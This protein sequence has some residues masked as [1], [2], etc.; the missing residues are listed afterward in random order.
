[1][2]CASFLEG[3]VAACF[4]LEWGIDPA[5]PHGLPHSFSCGLPFLGPQSG[6]RQ[7]V[8]LLL[9]MSAT[10]ISLRSLDDLLLRLLSVDLVPRL[11]LNSPFHHSEVIPSSAQFT[12]RL[13]RRS[14]ARDDALVSSALSSLHAF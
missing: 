11:F 10:L 6:A 2:Q 12:F 1:M 14:G 7:L 9:F 3:C 4:L 5:L 13:H 8:R